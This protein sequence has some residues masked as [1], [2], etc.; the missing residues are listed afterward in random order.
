MQRDLENQISHIAQI[1]FYDDFIHSAII[2][3]SVCLP[4]IRWACNE[5]T[6]CS[7]FF[8]VYSHNRTR[9]RTHAIRSTREHHTI[10]AISSCE[11][12]ASSARY[13]NVCHLRRINHTARKKDVVV[14]AICAKC[15]KSTG[16]FTQHAIS[17]I[18]S[19]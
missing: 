11:M 15:Q 9:T 14:Y 19:D 16:G 3:A 13:F 8:I 4:L 17:I 6:N 10:C 5:Y 2:S 7:L 18:N 1:H 12:I